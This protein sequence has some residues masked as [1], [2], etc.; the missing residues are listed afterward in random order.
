MTAPAI[1]AQD[2]SYRID[3]KT[4]LDN[5]SFRVEAGAYLS[6]VGPNGAGKSTLLKCLNR[7]LRGAGGRILIQGRPLAAYTQAEL[8]VQ[9]GYV[10]QG[11][12]DDSPF[13]VY[14]FVM[15]G[16]Y[17]HLSAF[18]RPAP[19][20]ASRV[21]DALDMVDARTLIHRQYGT[22]SGG[23][24]QRALIAAALAQDARILLLD[25]PTAFL[26]PHHQRDIL[27]LLVKLN[28]ESGLTVVSVTHDINAAALSAQKALALREGRVLFFGSQDDLMDSGVLS[29]LYGQEFHFV[30]HPVNGRRLIVPEALR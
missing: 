24:K 29:E 20:D 25:E 12:P 4:I 21:A 10:P 30:P 6:I 8:A 18:T 14:E 17:P 22:L 15:M 27:R 7:I 3:G 5:V 28:R 19:E 9:V 1:E 13:T 26:D 16:R 2:V 11:R 23:E